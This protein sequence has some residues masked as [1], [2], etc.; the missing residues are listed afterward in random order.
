MIGFN[1]V[2]L[3]RNAAI[4]NWDRTWYVGWV[5]LFVRLH[6][7]FFSFPRHPSYDVFHE[8]HRRSTE[9]GASNYWILNPVVGPEAITGSSRMKVCERRLAR[10]KMTTHHS[11]NPQPS[12]GGSMTQILLNSVFLPALHN[13]MADVTPTKA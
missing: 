5:A 12:Q 9:V 2:S 4:E 6:A 10:H 3:A 1:P 7:D 11:R 8:L 13:I